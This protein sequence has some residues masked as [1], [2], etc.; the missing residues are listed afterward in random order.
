MDEKGNIDDEATYICK[1]MKS[2][3]SS[4]L[5][6]ISAHFS[7]VKEDARALWSLIKRPRVQQRAIDYLGL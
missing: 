5:M 1:R 2:G 6:S 3:P 7:E 4:N